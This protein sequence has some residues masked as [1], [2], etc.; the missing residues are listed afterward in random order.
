MSESEKIKQL[1]HEQVKHLKLKREE[2]LSRVQGELDD[3]EAALRHLGQIM[4]ASSSSGATKKKRR[5]RVEDE[6]IVAALRSFMSPGQ[7]Y[8]AA[9]ILKKADLKAPRFAAFK[10][11]H[12]DFLKSHG[13]KRSMRYSLEG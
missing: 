7:S 5:E 6:Q 10:A 11:K 2:V 4:P 13:A 12:K 1:L 8:T 9:E 3:I